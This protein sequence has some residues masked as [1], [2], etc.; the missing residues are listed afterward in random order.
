MMIPLR[1]RCGQARGS[2]GVAPKSGMHLVC[3]C[4]DCRAFAHAL[5]RADLLDDAGGSEVFVTTPSRLS[6][7]S[8]LEQLRCMRLSAEGMLRWY[9][10]CC[11]TP[12][13]N[14]MHRPGIPAVS[15][16]RAF[17]DADDTTALGPVTRLN[18]RFARGA[19]PAGAEQSTS[20]ATMVRIVIFMLGARL[21]AAHKPNPLFLDNKPVREPR[22]LG[23]AE[24][25][26]LREPISG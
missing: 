9:W 3:Y 10:A 13:A 24:R 8:G 14:T 18:A 2:L 25:D 11:N 6:V 1:C 20:L 26:A 17:I 4:D 15:I 16:H 19:V 21:R 5:G 23:A 7:T 22:V 12:L